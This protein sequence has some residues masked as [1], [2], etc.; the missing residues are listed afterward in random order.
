MLDRLVPEIG[1]DGPAIDA[2]LEQLTPAEHS[3]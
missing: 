2:V 3:T 1:L